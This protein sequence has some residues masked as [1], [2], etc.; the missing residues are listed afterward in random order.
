M[1]NH[2]RHAETRFDI[3]EVETRI[4]RA[5]KTLYAVPDRDAR[6][7]QRLKSYWPETFDPLDYPKALMSGRFS[8]TPKD[9]DRY[10][11]DL[12]WLR[13]LDSRDAK[14][15]FGYVGGASFGRMAAWF[16]RSDETVRRWYRDA[17]KRL[18]ARANR[19][20]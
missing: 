13:A 15:I 5:I 20:A 9:I 6:Y 19:F 8:P 4:H 12:E 2:N 11:D 16:G 10:L 7:R 18:W 14:I 17:M 1:L 3:K